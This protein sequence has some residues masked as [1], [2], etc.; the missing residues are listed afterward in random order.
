MYTFAL[1]AINSS[2]TYYS[3][4]SASIHP[5][6]CQ[7]IY[8]HSCYYHY[9]YCCNCP[10]YYITTA[11]T[12]TASIPAPGT[13]A[14]PDR[15]ATDPDAASSGPLQHQPLT[16]CRYISL[17]FPVILSIL[18]FLSDLSA[19]MSLSLSPLSPCLSPSISMTSLSLYLSLQ[20]TCG[21]SSPSTVYRSPAGPPLPRSPVS[22]VPPFPEC[23]AVA[24]GAR[25]QHGVGQRALHEPPAAARPS[26]APP[27]PPGDATRQV[28][29]V[30]TAAEPES[31]WRRRSHFEPCPREPPLDLDDA[32]LPVSE[33]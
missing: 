13:C 2:T 23:P 9:W 29:A 25:P 32:D 6:C 15:T 10:H 14:A 5:G 11:T 8:Q 16:D 17:A 22:A 1:Q 7:N 24:G 19:L 21:C 27:L 3:T 33:V 20:E 18:F 12:C 4:V 30:A 31:P 28:T 26:P